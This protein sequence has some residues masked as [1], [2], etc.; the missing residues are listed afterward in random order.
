[1]IRMADPRMSKAAPVLVS[2]GNST[3]AREAVRSWRWSGHLI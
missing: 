3:S 1:M 2:E